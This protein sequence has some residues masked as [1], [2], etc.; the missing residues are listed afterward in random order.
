MEKESK[1]WMAQTGYAEVDDMEIVRALDLDPNV[2]YSNAINRVAIVAAE[3]QAYNG[4][5]ATGHNKDQAKR[6]S[7][8]DSRHAVEL[9]REA[10]KA[11]GK[12][13]L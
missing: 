5:I 1:N 4:Y 3:K 9:I 8:A 6:L 11:S 13:L 10:E 2:A 7:Q 12:T